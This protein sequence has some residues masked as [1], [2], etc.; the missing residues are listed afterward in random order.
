MY[1]NGIIALPAVKS[2]SSLERNKDLRYG[3]IVAQVLFFLWLP[4]LYYFIF[5]PVEILSVLAASSRN[6]GKENALAD[7]REFLTAMAVN[8]IESCPEDYKEIAEEAFKKA[9]KRSNIYRENGK[10]RWENKTQQPKPEPQPETPKP[11]AKPKPEK[12]A[13]DQG[14]FVRVTVD[15]E[16]ALRV[17]FGLD[18]GRAVQILAD[19]KESKG[20]A[21]RSDAA[22]MRGWVYDRIQ[23]DK[24]R[25]EP[26]KS[27]QQQERERQG[28]LAR[29][30]M[31]E[32]ERRRYGIVE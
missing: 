17:K 15:E 26:Q 6:K 10:K 20:K 9:T 11:P 12:H 3:A 13:L 1:I 27:F 30:L 14:G 19:Y 5:N 22:A 25:K 8:D 16:A 32:E 31:T 4:M 2:F 7:I 29:S 24:R 23:E 18:F 28:A 21:Y